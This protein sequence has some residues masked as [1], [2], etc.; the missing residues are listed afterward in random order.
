MGNRAEE[1]RLAEYMPPQFREQCPV[2]KQDWTI[3]RS[4]F[5]ERFASVQVWCVTKHNDDRACFSFCQS[6]GY[7]PSQIETAYRWLWR[8]YVQSV[9][10]RAAI[11][12][13][14]SDVAVKPVFIEDVGVRYFP[15]H[16]EAC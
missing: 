2:C 11:D 8:N 10:L 16:N 3:K 15:A 6:I 7:S 1:N 4:V 14:N 12:Q 9:G 13:C 5:H